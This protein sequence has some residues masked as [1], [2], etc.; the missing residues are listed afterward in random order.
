MAIIDEYNIELNLDALKYFEENTKYFFN[1]NFFDVEFQCK[2]ERYVIY[3]IVYNR[4]FVSYIYNE[5]EE[6]FKFK[7]IND[8]YKN[9]LT[10]KNCKELFKK[11]NIF[12]AIIDKDNNKCI[13][14]LDLFL[15]DVTYKEAVN[16]S[17]IT[18]VAPKI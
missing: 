6:Y 3:R 9:K 13:F 18:K 2:R 5:T 1:P 17:N 10:E 14:D 7:F 4:I 16:L 12:E 8:F 15:N 11:K